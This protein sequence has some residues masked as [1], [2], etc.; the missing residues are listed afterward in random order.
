MVENGIGMKDK[1]KKGEYAGRKLMDLK[2]KTYMFHTIGRKVLETVLCKD[3]S[4][5][6]WDSMKAKYSGSA[7]VRRA[8]LQALWRE[9]EL[10]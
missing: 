6:I 1:E 2:A 8:Q 5:D 4:K 9:F 10:L 7:R 3:S